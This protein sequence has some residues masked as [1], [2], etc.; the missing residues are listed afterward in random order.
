MDEDF[1]EEMESERTVG[2]MMGR[3]NKKDSMR[4]H[5]MDMEVSNLNLQ[6]TLAFYI[7]ALLHNSF[8]DT[9]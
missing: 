6:L 3:Y 4:M 8:I 5:R 1:D 7:L 2:K 9:L